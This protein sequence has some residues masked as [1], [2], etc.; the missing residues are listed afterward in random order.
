M[1]LWTW[2]TPGWKTMES[3]LPTA[4]TAQPKIGSRSRSPSTPSRIFSTLNTLFSSTQK[5]ATWSAHQNGQFPST[6]TNTSP[7]SNQQPPSSP[8]KSSA[9]HSKRFLTSL[10]THLPLQPTTHHGT[11]TT[12]T[13]GTVKSGKGTSLGRSRSP[14]IPPSPR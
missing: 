6:S 1:N 2:Y 9:E 7:Q 3:Q 10:P 12:V 8:P 14:P 11:P 13:Q 4:N 5:G